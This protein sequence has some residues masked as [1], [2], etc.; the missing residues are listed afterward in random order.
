VR[1]RFFIKNLLA[2]ISEVHNQDIDPQRFWEF[3]EKIEQNTVYQEKVTDTICIFIDKFV[4]T[5][6]SIIMARLFRSF[7]NGS[8]DFNKFFDLSLCLERLHPRSYVA[9]KKLAETETFSSQTRNFNNLGISN[10]HEGLLFSAGIVYRNGTHFMI[11]D[12]GKELYYNGF[13]GLPDHIYNHQ[14][15]PSKQ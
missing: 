1:E 13:A 7:I 10:V 11:T 12:L 9:L 6:Q 2:F 3:K 14:I 4:H 5:S 15:I 8:I